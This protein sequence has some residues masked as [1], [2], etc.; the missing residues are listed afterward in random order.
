MVEF[1]VGRSVFCAVYSNCKYCIGYKFNGIYLENYIGHA[2]RVIFAQRNPAK[3]AFPY[4]LRFPDTHIL[5]TYVLCTYMPYVVYIRRAPPLVFS[6]PFPLSSQAAPPSSAFFTAPCRRDD[7]E[8]PTRR[9]TLT[10]LCALDRRRRTLQRCS[11][12]GRLRTDRA[13]L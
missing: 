11:V 7:G 6:T 4:S 9:H 12:G 3:C 13:R 10:S 2:T 8:R 5:F 1:H